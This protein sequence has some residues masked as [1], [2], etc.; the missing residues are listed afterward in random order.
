[1]GGNID[2][3]KK[4]T[5]T[6]IDA[7]N[8]VEP[9]VNAEKAKCMLMSCHQN[10][11]RNNN[12][13]TANRSFEN[14]AQFKYLGTTVTNENLIQEEI[15]RR[16]NSGNACYHSFQNLLSFRLLSKNVKIRIY[17]T[18]LLP[19]VLYGCETRSLTLREEHR[20]RVSE[21]GVLRIEYLD[22]RGMK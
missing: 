19:V 6:L 8:E 3:I 9:E 15:K 11:G 4:N 10:A 17:K 20:L 1:L 2:T 13:R 18:I 16:L 14:V 12:V 5:V 7:N 22:R 21:N